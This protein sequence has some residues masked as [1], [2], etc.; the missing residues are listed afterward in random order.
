MRDNLR[1]DAEVVALETETTELQET[2]LDRELRLF[3]AGLPLEGEFGETA[4]FDSA[5]DFADVPILS[6]EDGDSG[7]LELFASEMTNRSRDVSAEED[8][9]IASA[10]LGA[11]LQRF[12]VADVPPGSTAESVGLVPGDILLEIDDIE[13]IGIEDLIAAED[14]NV[15]GTAA[16]A[17][18]RPRGRT[19][20][21]GVRG[22]PSVA[23]VS[24][25][26]G[27]SW[28]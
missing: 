19:F 8:R 25:V 4:A 21:A 7:T 15:E 22:P 16:R 12:V 13:V 10:T 17:D 6:D 20:P 11:P 28:R 5:D 27:R 23:C 3:S 9:A 1:L 24:S 2:L 14:G 26:V 18:R